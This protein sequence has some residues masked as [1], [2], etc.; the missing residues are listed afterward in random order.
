MAQPDVV[1]G[2]ELNKHVQ[3]RIYILHNA[4]RRVDTSITETSVPKGKQ[5]LHKHQSHK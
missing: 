5:A 2:L 3:Y 4:M 1:Y